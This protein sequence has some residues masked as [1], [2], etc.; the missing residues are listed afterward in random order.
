MQIEKHKNDIELA[1]ANHQA[2]QE[3]HDK[4]QKAHDEHKENLT[5]S[6]D[7]LERELN[8]SKRLQEQL[9]YAQEEISV[10]REK[11]EEIGNHASGISKS[12]DVLEQSLEPPGI[13]FNTFSPK[14]YLHTP[15]T[16]Y[17]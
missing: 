17:C 2:V 5:I 10:L 11:I 8:K 14:N 13:A 12:K 3:L 4:L 1:N 7:N 16:R 6:A 9:H 15:S